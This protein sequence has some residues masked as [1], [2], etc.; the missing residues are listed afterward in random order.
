ML[1][2]RSDFSSVDILGTLL[3]RRENNSGF[4]RAK[5]GCELKMQTSAVVLISSQLFDVN[6]PAY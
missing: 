5:F 1:E 6:Q 4:S 2:V 3:I